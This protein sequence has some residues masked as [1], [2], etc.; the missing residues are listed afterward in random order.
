[1]LKFSE[2]KTARRYLY[3]KVFL[4]AFCVLVAVMIHATYGMYRKAHNARALLAQTQESLAKMREREAYF[5][6]EIE[7]LKSESGVE[8]EIRKKFRVAKS[9]E[10]VIIITDA[11]AENTAG[12]LS[13]RSIF[14]KFFDFFR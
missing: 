9:G 3:S 4:A 8:K 14:Q 7:G 10:H 2:K 6:H 1:M 11:P 5:S 12:S 13:D